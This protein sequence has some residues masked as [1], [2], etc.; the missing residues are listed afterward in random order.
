MEMAFRSETATGKGR[1]TRISALVILL[2]TSCLAQQGVWQVRH[3]HLRKGVTGTLRVSADSIAFEE[4]DKKGKTAVHSRTWKYAEIQRLVLGNSTLRIVTYEDQKW[5]LG[6]DR[7]FVFD[8]V[9]AGMSAELF[10]G[11]RGRLDTRFVAALADP[12]V[13]GEWQVPVKLAVGRGGSQGVLLV[14][15]DGMVYSTKGEAESR[16]WRDRDI[17]SVSSSGPFDLTVTTPE[18]EFRFQ[19]KEALP[20]ARYNALWRRI[21]RS[22]GLQMLTIGK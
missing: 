4:K 21:A 2:A 7:E 12:L 3:Q 20:E 22:G 19:L 18:R 8:Q 1:G 11:W 6:R 10:A 17:E 15:G 13:R 14:S 9:P 5:E 16:T